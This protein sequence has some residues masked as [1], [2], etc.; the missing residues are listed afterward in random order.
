VSYRAAHTGLVHSHSQVDPPSA[1]KCHHVRVTVQRRAAETVKKAGAQL[2]GAGIGLAA[3]GPLGALVGAASVPIVE[4]VVLRERQSLRNM[5]LLIEM[6][7]EL[8]GVSV[9]EF[10]ACATE[11]DGRF[12]LVTSALQAAYNVSCAPDT[13]PL[14]STFSFIAVNNWNSSDWWH[15]AQFFLWLVTAYVFL[16]T[17]A[18]SLATIFFAIKFRLGAHDL[19]PAL[20]PLVDLTLSARAFAIALKGKALILWLPFIPSRLLVLIS[21][22]LHEAASYRFF[23]RDKIPTKAGGLSETQLEEV[24]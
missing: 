6:V 18:G 5:E 21:T 20:A 4:L 23:E 19:H 9:D 24:K 15:L 11:G 2:A 22:G 13:L 7:T 16:A 3:G 1:L 8:C 17:F 14:D 10:A 12:F